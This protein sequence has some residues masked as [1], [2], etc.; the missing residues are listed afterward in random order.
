[1]ENN[2]TR[3]MFFFT[4]T[5]ARVYICYNSFSEKLLVLEKSLC[6]FLPQTFTPVWGKNEQLFFYPKLL[7]FLP[8]VIILLF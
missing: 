1:M 2:E 8:Q 6:S 5:K 4:L 3:G 7:K